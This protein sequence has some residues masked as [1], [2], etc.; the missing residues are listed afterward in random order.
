MSGAQR[1]GM[2]L[3]AAAGGAAMVPASGRAAVVPLVSDSLA[4][5]VVL[6]RDDWAAWEPL[7]LA[8]LLERL[9]GVTLAARGGLGSTTLVNITGSV[10]G[11][12]VLFLDGIALN[13][14]ELEWPRISALP[15]VRVE[16]V[17]I[18]RGCDPAI[19]RVWSRDPARVLS[20]RADFD[21][22]RGG[23][24]TRSRRVAFTTPPRAL[25]VALD[26][27][28]I[29]RGFETFSGIE[30]PSLGRPE[31]A[32]DQRQ[33]GVR[34]TLRRPDDETVQVSHA[35]GN[36][37]AHGS[38][39][40]A[41]DV[42]SQVWVRNGLRWQR[43]VHGAGFMV[44][45]G[46][47]A[48]D[49][50]RKREGVRDAV[51]EA[52][53]T[54]AV[55]VYL[56]ERGGWQP[57]LRARA[58][59][60]TGDRGSLH[61]EHGAQEVEVRA[62]RPGMLRLEAAASGHHDARAGTDWGAHGRAIMRRGTWEWEARASRDVGFSGWGVPGPTSVR[63]GH[64]VVA[65]VARN[66]ARGRI[67]LESFAKWME[68]G[69]AE[70]P[71]EFPYVAGSPE[72]Q[73]GVLIDA[74]QALGSA[75]WGADLSASGAWMP[76]ARGGTAGLPEWQSRLAARLRT[77]RFEGDLV[78]ALRCEARFD[79]ARAF[80]ATTQIGARAVGD[81]TLELNFLQRM[82]FFW[83]VRNVFDTQVAAAPGVLESPRRSFLGLRV[84]ISD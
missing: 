33:L 31:G 65:G 28:E 39:A 7:T 38:F 49:R 62:R 24:E 77:T 52:R 18:D 47:Q 9:A 29:L 11:R 2:L 64:G 46:H 67:A 3:L 72:T 17:E 48:W 84:V 63:V 69:A 54:A 68:G 44:D 14:P 80:D 10:A 15:L 6:D 82:E 25:S 70:I 43:E 59:Q 35:R 75:R 58:A 61:H 81:A 1:I 56:P 83:S 34:I 12:V 19:V 79:A 21:M 73:T 30:T 26:Y 23:L 50:D 32:F 53:T 51:T 22:G 20:P 16:R 4:T 45:V 57:A 13:E 55:D 74:A 5:G 71:V 60:T 76:P 78:L 8:E 37:N 66:G 42:E 36:A 41:D 27:D 40:A